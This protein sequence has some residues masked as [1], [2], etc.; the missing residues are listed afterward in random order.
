MQFRD[1][2]KPEKSMFLIEGT[3]LILDSKDNVI[4]AENLTD[5]GVDGFSFE[6]KDLPRDT[7]TV[8][9]KTSIDADLISAMGGKIIDKNNGTNTMHYE[10]TTTDQN[11]KEHTVSG[12]S[13]EDYS[14]ID[15]YINSGSKEGDID[16]ENRVIT[17]SVYVNELNQDLTGSEFIIKDTFGE[18]QELLINQL[19]SN[20]ILWRKMEI[21]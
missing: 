18:K 7:Y 4:E 12:E 20:N 15:R 9:Y 3:L 14:L 17:W 6:L 10:G 21:E 13:S 11:N 16:R 5:S 19:L 2:F 8:R 1:T